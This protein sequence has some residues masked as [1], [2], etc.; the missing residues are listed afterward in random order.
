[1]KMNVYSVLQEFRSCYIVHNYK[2]YTFLTQPTLLNCAMFLF[3]RI[4]G[5]VFTRVNTVETLLS[6]GHPQ[7]QGYDIVGAICTYLKY[8]LWLAV[9]TIGIVT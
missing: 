5:G 3:Q 4:K 2:I 6:R 1:M 7:D 9:K 8:C